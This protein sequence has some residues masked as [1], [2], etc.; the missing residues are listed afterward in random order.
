MFESL[1]A[2]ADG[3]RLESHPINSRIAFGSGELKTY[4]GCDRCDEYKFVMI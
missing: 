3:R 1:N 4:L 2:R